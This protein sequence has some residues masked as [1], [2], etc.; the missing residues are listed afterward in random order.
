MFY[1]CISTGAIS[2]VRRW[3]NKNAR[4][5]FHKPSE[6]FLVWGGRGD[7]SVNRASIV[8][9]LLRDDCL[10]SDVFLN[11]FFT[12]WQRWGEVNS[13]V[14]LQCSSE[15]IDANSAQ[16]LCCV[17]HCTFLSKSRVCVSNFWCLKYLTWI[18]HSQSMPNS[19]SMPRSQSM[20]HI[21]SMPHS[22]S[23]HLRFLMFLAWINWREFYTARACRTV[24]VCHTVRVCRVARVRH[25][26]RVCL[27][28]FWCFLA[29]QRSHCDAQLPHCR[30][31]RRSR[32]RL[33]SKIVLLQCTLSCLHCLPVV[34]HWN[35]L[36]VRIMDNADSTCIHIPHNS[37]FANL[38]L[39]LVVQARNHFEVNCWSAS[40]PQWNFLSHFE[41]GS[42]AVYESE[43]SVYILGGLCVKHQTDRKSVV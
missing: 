30:R 2:A 32:H 27:K 18:L 1:N 22:Q 33:G 38:N 9:F 34:E 13:S 6:L 15:L 14:E 43:R 12:H 37:Y 16:T 7:D 31:S 4:V 3:K 28:F 42:I 26:A 23:V 5:Q 8:H 41:R 21:K 39:V 25:T 35:F 20:P 11:S 19:Q 10:L 17:R 36:A 29:A 40:C 24:R